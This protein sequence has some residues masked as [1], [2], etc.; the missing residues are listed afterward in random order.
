MIRQMAGLL[1]F[2]VE[3]AALWSFGEWAFRLPLSLPVRGAS[4]IAAPLAIAVVWGLF[5]S[6]KAHWHLPVAVA[7][8][9]K[10]IIFAAA[11]GLAWTMGQVYF[12]GALAAL[13]GAS[14]A[15]EYLAG[16]KAVSPRSADM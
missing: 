14:L 10:F 12:A 8:A 4:A 7:A 1:A 2:G 15:L 6:P 9:G 3:L 16:I 5:L 13:A 11:V